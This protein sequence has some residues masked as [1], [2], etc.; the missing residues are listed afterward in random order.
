MLNI[1][2]R[3]ETSKVLFSKNQEMIMKMQRA[4]G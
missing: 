2:G 1:T 3:K 4:S